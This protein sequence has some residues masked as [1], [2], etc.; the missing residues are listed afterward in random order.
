M[1]N[2]LV[3]ADDIVDA[4]GVVPD[5]AA[6]ND[7]DDFGFGTAGSPSTAP[8]AISVAAVSNSQVFAPALG[9]FNSAGAQVLHVPIQT[10]G[11]TP[12][13][14]ASANQTLVD[15]GSI[16]GRN[17][18]PVER[19]LCGSP[20]DP[21][22]ADNPLPASSLTGAI[23][24]VSRGT[25]SFASKAGRARAAGAIGIVLVDNRFGEA[26][27]LPIQ[28]QIPAAMIADV[29][30]AALRAAIG[31]AGRIQIRIGQ[32]TE[33]IAT[34]RSGIVTSFSGAG[35]TAFGHLLKPDL[36]AP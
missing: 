18:Q 17:G 10:G 7:R 22:G 8:D 9:A 35:P 25:C 20:A 11:Q 31:S 21:N 12:P 33:D 26:N 14:W 24:L 28:L 27:P 6:G 4:A 23:A 32:G 34:G 29:D 30:G 36:A 16:I 1:T 13:A 15:V 19:H 3:A 2:I 5:I